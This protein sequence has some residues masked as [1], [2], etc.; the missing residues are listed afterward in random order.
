MAARLRG[1]SEQV[2]SGR[3][4]LCSGTDAGNG[5]CTVLYKLKVRNPAVEDF[6]ESFDE[7]LEIEVL[8]DA[9]KRAEYDE[10]LLQGG[11]Q[12]GLCSGERGTQADA[13][14]DFS[15]LSK[16]LLLAGKGK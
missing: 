10:S 16:A 2:R 7:D 11:A 15:L 8:N 9:E 14:P 13:L 4:S 1:H 3:D 5:Y 6:I 12:D